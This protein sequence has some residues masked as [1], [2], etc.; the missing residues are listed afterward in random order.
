MKITSFSNQIGVKYYCI[1]NK[2][3]DYWSNDFGWMELINEADEFPISIFTEEEK[4]K[5]NLPIQGFWE[6]F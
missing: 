4:N 3:G 5:F 1:R 2:E 6:I